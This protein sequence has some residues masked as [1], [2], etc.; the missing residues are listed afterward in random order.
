MTN[1][2]RIISQMITLLYVS[3][4]SYHTEGAC[5]QYLVKL[6]KYFK[7]SLQFRCSTYVLCKL[8]KIQ[9]NKRCTVHI[10]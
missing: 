7:C 1:K 2:C 3:T 9:N 5:N 10:L 4:L 6:H 8:V